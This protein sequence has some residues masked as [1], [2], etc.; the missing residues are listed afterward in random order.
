[1]GQRLPAPVERLRLAYLR[2]LRRNQAPRPSEPEPRSVSSGSGDA[3]CG[4]PFADEPAFWSVPFAAAAPR[5]CFFV[6]VC[7]VVVWSVV[8]LLLEG[9]ALWSVLLVPLVPAAPVD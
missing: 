5:L 9:A 1:M 3:V 6:V 4:I 8:V 2:T 7:D